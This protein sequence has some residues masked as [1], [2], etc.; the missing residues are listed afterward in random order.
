MADLR[1]LCFA[2]FFFAGYCLVNEAP[3]KTYVTDLHATTLKDVRDDEID[4]QS[5]LPV[6]HK[7]FEADVMTHRDLRNDTTISRSL[8]TLGEWEGYVINKTCNYWRLAEYARG[9]SFVD[10][11]SNIGSWMIPMAKCAQEMGGKV[12]G[13]EAMPA[14]NAFLRAGMKYNHFNNVHLYEYAVGDESMPP[15]VEMIWNFANQGKGQ[16]FSANLHVREEHNSS[17][18]K[19]PGWRKYTGHGGGQT[20]IMVPGTTVDTIME[21]EGYFKSKERVFAIKVDVEGFERQ[22]VLGAS[23]LFE[24]PP[25]IIYIEVKQDREIEN[26]I[27]KDYGYHCHGDGGPKGQYGPHIKERHLDV[28][29]EQPKCFQGKAFKGFKM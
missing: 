28:W 10:V 12:V 21:N 18:E 8:Q 13:V 7:F 22:A 1:T 11:G 5:M 26:W 2:S 29:C 27:A 23:R 17:F 3:S 4:L 14:N 6:R 25:C 15:S 16:V 20:T 19:S 24:H 9:W